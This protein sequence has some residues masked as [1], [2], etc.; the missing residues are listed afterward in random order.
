MNENKIPERIKQGLD[1]YMEY[2]VLPGHFLKCVLMNDLLGAVRR[3]D[4]DSHAALREIVFYVYDKLPG[5][6]I[7][8]Q[9]KV[10]AW[11]EKK[12]AAATAAKG[13]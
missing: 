11:S 6:S 4:P 12:R 5:E 10:L 2:G 9:E 3:A 1:R 7:G 13:G 8:S